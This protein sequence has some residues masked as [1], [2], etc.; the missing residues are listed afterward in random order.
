MT[1]KGHQKCFN[2]RWKFVPK[3]HSE[4]WSEKFL[5]HLPQT[6]SQVSAHA[7]WYSSVLVLITRTRDA[8]QLR[9]TSCV[10]NNSEDN[11]HSLLTVVLL[12]RVGVKHDIVQFFVLS[13]YTRLCVCLLIIKYAF[14][15]G[16]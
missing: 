9:M 5:L 7:Q 11:Y 12:L 14:N 2:I 10:R 6:Q 1:K 15:R 4:I 13:M 8:T 16:V 3:S